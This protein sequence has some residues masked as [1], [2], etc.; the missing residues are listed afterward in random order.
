M[1]PAIKFNPVIKKTDSLET[2]PTIKIEKITPA[3]KISDVIT[4]TKADADTKAKSARTAMIFSRTNHFFYPPDPVM[5]YEDAKIEHNSQ[6]TPRNE[7]PT[8]RKDQLEEQN[9]FQYFLD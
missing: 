1:P 7:C 9:E 4:K 3:P 5:E 6:E 8:A 2:G